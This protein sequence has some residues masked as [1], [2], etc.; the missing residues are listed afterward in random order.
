M[1]VN[2]I[3]KNRTYYI[4][5]LPTVILLFKIVPDVVNNTDG[6][7]ELGILNIVDDVVNKTDGIVE[8]NEVNPSH[9]KEPITFNELWH[10]IG[11]EIVFNTT[12]VCP[13]ALA[14]NPK[15]LSGEVKKPAILIDNLLDESVVNVLLFFNSNILNA[16][17]FI[18]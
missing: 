3:W 18:G 2:I 8:F 5:T 4:Y 17:P 16:V 15:S 6:I 12:V 10:V 11:C 13:E 14:T 1:S 9:V 7:V